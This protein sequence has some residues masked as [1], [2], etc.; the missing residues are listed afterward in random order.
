MIDAAF[1]TLSFARRMEQAGFT[2]VQAEALAHEQGRLIDERLATKSDIAAVRVSIEESRR[3]SAVNI[4]GLRQETRSLI[5][6]LRHD[7][8]INLGAMI[9]A[10][11]AVASTLA[12][13]LARLPLRP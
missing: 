9:I 6:V 5:E 1:D 8:V 3:E 7:M 13:L 11:V 10:G 12:S 2:R 4:E